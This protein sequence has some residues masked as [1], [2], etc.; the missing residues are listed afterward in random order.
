LTPRACTKDYKV[1]LAPPGAPWVSWT[2][3]KNGRQDRH[4]A[5][6]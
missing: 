6:P 1:H 3:E 5:H 4:K 2:E